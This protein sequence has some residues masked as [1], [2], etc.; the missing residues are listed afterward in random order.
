VSDYG[1]D[2]R[3]IGV[4]SPAEAKDFPLASV[5]RPVLVPTQPPV[6]WVPRLLSPGL[7]RGRDVTLTTH[8]SSDEVV[9]EYEICISSPPKRL[10][11]VLWDRF[12]FSF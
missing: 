2:N 1:L 7:K 8:P 11:A 4:G 6:Q 3:A 10:H 9:N 5:S 12:N